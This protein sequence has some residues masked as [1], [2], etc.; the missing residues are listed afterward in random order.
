MLLAAGVPAAVGWKFSVLLG[1]S[2]SEDTSSFI[3]I[4]ALAGSNAVAGMAAVWLW[5]IA[6]TQHLLVASHFLM[7]NWFGGLSCFFAL[8]FRFLIVFF[9]LICLQDLI[10]DRFKN[11][12]PDLSSPRRGIC[13]QRVLWIEAVLLCCIACTDG[14]VFCMQSQIPTDLG[15]DLRPELVEPGEPQPQAFEEVAR[16]ILSI[17][18][19]VVVV[20]FL[21]ALVVLVYWACRVFS[22]LLGVID[23]LGAAEQV[24]RKECNCAATQALISCR[25]TVFLQSRGLIS[26]L[27]TTAFLFI[28][29]A[30]EVR[31]TPLDQPSDQVYGF[32]WSRPS[33]ALPTMQCINSLVNVVGVILL[34]KAHELFGSSLQQ[35]ALSW[36]RPIRLCNCGCSWRPVPRSVTDF[37]SGWEANTEELAGRGISLGNLVDF[38]SRLF[39]SER[40]SFQPPRSTPPRMW[41][42]SKYLE[43][44]PQTSAA[45]TSFA[46][47]VNDGKMVTHNWSNLFRDLMAT[48]IADALGEHTFEF[49]AELLCDKEGVKV[50]TETLQVHDCLQDTYWICAFS[51]STSMQASAEQNPDGDTDPVTKIPH[52]VCGCKTPKFF[53]K[54]PPVNEQGESIM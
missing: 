43:I 1:T 15:P 51:L 19:S 29:V 38:Y 45:G 8:R 35:T 32:D 11:I 48:V 30:I 52:P 50:L 14:L 28:A 6:P 4:W 9:E 53:N 23:I 10:H 27:A 46:E 39:D 21:A 7:P 24:A 54:D 26:S 31:N 36:I 22:A 42:D 16:L 13:L 12:W 47:L 34:S 25:M 44:I 37:A 5:I 17:S 2:F 49:V 41:S 3:L 33:I 18:Q 40:M 20:S